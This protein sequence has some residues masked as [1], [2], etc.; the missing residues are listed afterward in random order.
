MT[1]PLISP[2]TWT[3]IQLYGWSYAKLPPILF[4]IDISTNSPGFQ[5]VARKPNWFSTIFHVLYFIGGVVTVLALPVSVLKM[6]SDTNQTTKRIVATSLSILHWC[7]LL[8]VLATNR[9]LWINAHCIPI[10]NSMINN[11]LNYRKLQN[12]SVMIKS[13]YPN[14]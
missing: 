4:D 3:A 6:L 2:L 11:K 9:T 8:Y 1:N 13:L 5:L 10:L 14:F 12:I 7:Y